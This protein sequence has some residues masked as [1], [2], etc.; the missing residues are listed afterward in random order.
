L[1]GASSSAVLAVN[2]RAGPPLAV[3]ITFAII[4]DG[5]EETLVFA[6]DHKPKASRRL[7]RLR[8][9]EADPRVAVLASGYDDDWRRLWWVRA[10]GT[11]VIHP[12]AAGPSGASGAPG[13]A[14][15]P[16]EERGRAVRALTDRYPQ[17]AGHE[18]RG[19]LVAIRIE[20]IT[21]WSG[22]DLAAD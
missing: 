17:Y 10:D 21:G 16:G 13:A 12:A 9:I 7:R 11:A 4:G 14:G 15:A 5:P 20:A 1:L 2:D 6:V 22:A 19:E 3:P 18:P 8:L